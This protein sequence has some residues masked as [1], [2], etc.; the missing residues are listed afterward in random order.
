MIKIGKQTEC[1][2]FEI[3]PRQTNLL[4]STSRSSLYSLE[5]SFLTGSTS[6]I[7]PPVKP[8]SI[9]ITP[10]PPEEASAAPDTTAPK[11][12]HVGLVPCLEQKLRIKID[13]AIEHWFELEGL[14]VIIRMVT[15]AGT[16]QSIRLIQPYSNWTICRSPCRCACRWAW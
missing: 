7:C 2:R 16:Y 15:A 11:S 12:W 3:G 4:C 9:G 1:S 5:S 10:S 8:T 14:S 6:W 13:N